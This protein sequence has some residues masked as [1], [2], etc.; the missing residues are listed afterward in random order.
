VEKYCDELKAAKKNS[1]L[2]G[3]LTYSFMGLMF[4]LIYAAYGVGFWY[5]NKLIVDYRWRK[6]R[7][8]RGGV[9]QG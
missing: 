9:L 8:G 3:T 2:K 4:G 6:W 7:Q 1:I 5:G